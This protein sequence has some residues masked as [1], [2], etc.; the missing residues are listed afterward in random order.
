MATQNVSTQDRLFS[1]LM[2]DIGKV[3]NNP[4]GAN[5]SGGIETAGLRN[6]WS[7][8]GAGTQSTNLIDDNINK[9]IAGLSQP[10]QPTGTGKSVFETAA[11]DAIGRLEGITAGTDPTTQMLLNRY[12]EEG[13]AASA[14]QQ[15][16][17]RQQAQQA[18]LSTLQTAQL[19]LQQQRDVESARQ[20]G[21]VGLATNLG[22][23]A[24]QAA[25]DKVAVAADLQ[26][27]KEN[28]LNNFLETTDLT[29]KD[30]YDAAIKMSGDVYG[31]PMDY[32]SLVNKQWESKQ[33]SANSRLTQVF[34]DIGPDASLD[35]IINNPAGQQALSEAW[36]AETKGS[37]GEID[38]DNLTPEQ[39]AWINTKT[40]SLGSSEMVRRDRDITNYANTQVASG[41]WT[42]EQA[43]QYLAVERAKSDLIS[44]SGSKVVKIG[45]AEYVK[46]ADGTLVY[47]GGDDVYE[48]AGSNNVIGDYGWDVDTGKLYTSSGTQYMYEN[49]K[50]IK[51]TDNG[52]TWVDAPKNEASSVKTA[53]GASETEGAIISSSD[54]TKAITNNEVVDWDNDKVID[55]L[56]SLAITVDANNNLSGDI[57]TAVSLVANRPEFAKELYNR[58]VKASGTVA[59]K[60]S[61]IEDNGGRP[62]RFSFG[63]KTGVMLGEDPDGPGYF[64]MLSDGTFAVV[65]PKDPKM[66]SLGFNWTTVDSKDINKYIK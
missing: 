55:A 66:K 41:R 35:T 30:G 16:S 54:V 6:A 17:L 44:T 53:I 34:T 51:S 52:M 48:S 42:R 11:S 31:K 4:S 40:Y 15:S 39:L 21:L 49:G 47:S 62:E 43:D 10:V 5:G 26:T 65:E 32:T 14:A 38:F 63:G 61:Y 45:G 29:T 33:K 23:R 46:T 24:D 25:R 7:L 36:S 27:Y 12:S 8:G 1:S 50:I 2:R 59:K 37:L 60:Y 28:E 3:S 19:G 56:D 58:I 22:A 20:E 13:A 57:D 64:V 9:S 18:G